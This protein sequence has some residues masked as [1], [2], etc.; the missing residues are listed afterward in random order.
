MQ[1]F[2]LCIHTKYG[3]DLFAFS[4]YEKAQDRLYKYVQD[5]WTSEDV[6]IQEYFDSPD[7]G[8]WYTIEPV[9]LDNEYI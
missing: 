5:W 7:L 6:A 8:A 4:S 9:E 2:I 3:N 1:I